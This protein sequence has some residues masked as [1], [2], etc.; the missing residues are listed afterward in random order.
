MKAHERDVYTPEP[1][2]LTPPTPRSTITMDD[3]TDFPE[4]E[5]VPL[6]ESRHYEEGRYR[7]PSLPA[8]AGIFPTHMYLHRGKEYSWCACGHTQ[9]SPFCDGQCK[10]ILTRCRPVS[11][12]VAESGYFKLCNCKLSANA[13]FCNST[14]QHIVRWG[15]KNHRGFWG[16]WGM[17]SFWGCFSYWFFTFYK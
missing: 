7:P 8:Y 10:W 17:V 2:I 6:M 1:K 9:I 15:H 16:M 4:Q 13:P 11:F 12:N 14:H 3:V 5:D